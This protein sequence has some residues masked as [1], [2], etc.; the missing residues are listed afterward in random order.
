MS[1][2]QVGNVPSIT[3][4]APANFAS[5]AV[6]GNAKNV[7]E[8]TT[9]SVSKDVTDNKTL[10]EFALY[11]KLPA[12]LQL[13]IMKL[14]LPEARVV[15]VRF[16]SYEHSENYDF[17]AN[18]PAALHVCQMWRTEAN[19][20][21][22]MIQSRV[23]PV[24]QVYIDFDVDS[25]YLRETEWFDQSTQPGWNFGKNFPQRDMVKHLIA[26]PSILRV[27]RWEVFRKPLSHNTPPAL[28]FFKNLV[29]VR[30]IRRCY[31]RLKGKENATLVI[32]YLEDVGSAVGIYAV[33]P[34][35]GGGGNTGIE[36]E[37]GRLC[38]E[39]VAFRVKYMLGKLAWLAPGSKWKMPT[40]SFGFYSFDSVPW[41]NRH[42]KPCGHKLHNTRSRGKKGWK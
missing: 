19:K 37:M 25:L 35:D 21:Y 23:E 1:E 2:R 12:E 24:Q 4:D 40:F 13:R 18:V 31:T 9:T 39:V 15:E 14:S 22:T 7:S 38:S 42:C 16:S 33:F 8:F 29:S 11:P 10:E 5:V 30:L 17:F 27:P 26:I 32:P 20:I 34:I 3:A 28:S 41:R 6:P 36:G